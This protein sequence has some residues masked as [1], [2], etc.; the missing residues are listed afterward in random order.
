[1]LKAHILENSKIYYKIF[2]HI[3][4]FD[5]IWLNLARIIANRDTKKTNK[6]LPKKKIHNP[7]VHWKIIYPQ[8][9]S[10]K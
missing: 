2:S 1:M 8:I 4:N 3:D 9:Q 6:E 7:S 5:K 10:K